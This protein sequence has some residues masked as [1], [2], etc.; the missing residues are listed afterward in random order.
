MV[1]AGTGHQQAPGAHHLKSAQVQF[2][3]SAQGSLDSSLAFRESGRIENDGVKDLDGVRPIAQ[4]LKRVR[5]HP[6]HLRRE[7]GAIGFQVSLRHLERGARGIDARDL[8]ADL[9][10]VQG[11]AALI[12]AHIERPPGRAQLLR[13]LLGCGV[14]CLLV[15]KSARLLSGIGVVVK[16]KSVK[17][18]LS[19]GGR[20]GGIAHK[21]WLGTGRCQLLQLAHPRVGAFQNGRRSQLLAKHAHT[22]LPHCGRIQS[23]GKQLENDQVGVFIHHHAGQFIG[24]AET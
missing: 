8:A 5:L 3:V 24:L 23:L 15:K 10:Q 9:G 20:L 18:E 16:H 2:F 13:P 21:Q 7:L 6:I 14:V 17:P 11:E 22:C 1:G 4:D 19:A 12:A